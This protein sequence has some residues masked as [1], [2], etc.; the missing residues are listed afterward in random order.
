MS[1][2]RPINTLCWLQNNVHRCMSFFFIIDS[3]SKKFYKK[4]VPEID[5][6]KKHHHNTFISDTR[7]M[8]DYLLKPRYMT[9]CILD[10]YIITM[11][12][13]IKRNINKLI[14]AGLDCTIFACNYDMN[15]AC[16]MHTTQ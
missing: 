13:S 12:F 5:Y 1:A 10:I 15:P 7:A 2:Y 11:Q 6:T 9:K 14:K 8:S 4:D 3:P 16:A